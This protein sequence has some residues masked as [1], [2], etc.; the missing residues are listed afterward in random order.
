MNIMKRLKKF[1][2]FSLLVLLF[3]CFVSVYPAVIASADTSTATV[4][5]SSTSETVA[6]DSGSG[7][8]SSNNLNNSPIGRGKYNWAY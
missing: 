5:S 8:V 7:G 6:T 4:S 2:V 1:T 3:S